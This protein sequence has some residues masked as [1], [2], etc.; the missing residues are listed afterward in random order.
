MFFLVSDCSSWCVVFWVRLMVLVICVICMFCGGVLVSVCNI[1]K[2][3]WM[4]LIGR[5]VGVLVVVVLL[6]CLFMRGFCLLG[7]IGG[8]LFVDVF[9]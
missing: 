6:L 5:E 9:Y 8:G 3:C 4:L 2:V 7:G 1:V